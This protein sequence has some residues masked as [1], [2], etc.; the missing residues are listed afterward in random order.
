MLL[1]DGDR[2]R[3]LLGTY[4]QLIDAGDF[5]GLGQLFA[6]AVLRDQSGAVIATGSAEGAALYAS[7]T[8]LHDAQHVVANTV[9]A[10]G[11]GDEEAVAT[12]AYVVFQ[13]IPELALQP[14]ITG[15]YLDTFARVDGEWRFS[16][17]RFS[18]GH[19]GDL[20]RHLTF[21]PNPGE[22]P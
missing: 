16:E 3:G 14:V 19:I 2:I 12:S 11:L 1:T 10:E 20:S 21:A 6:H 18:I 22:S 13:A 7:T 9:L 8:R 15:S 5:A 17:R 4:C